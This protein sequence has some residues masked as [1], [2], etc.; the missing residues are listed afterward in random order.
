VLAKTNP[1]AD[2]DGHLE[3]TSKARQEGDGT[4]APAATTRGLKLRSK[5][6]TLEKLATEFREKGNPHCSRPRHADLLEQTD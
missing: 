3:R 5:Q 1:S 4:S 6:M 2:V